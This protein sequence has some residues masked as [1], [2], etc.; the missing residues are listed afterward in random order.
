MCGRGEI[1]VGPVDVSENFSDGGQRVQRD[2]AVDIDGV[3]HFDEI[4]VLADFHAVGKGQ[5]KDLVGQCPITLRDDPRG[6]RNIRVGRSFKRN[7]GISGLI[8]SPG[9]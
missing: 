7:G 5:F 6:R 1:A 4:G 2:V 8:R 9:R 3:E